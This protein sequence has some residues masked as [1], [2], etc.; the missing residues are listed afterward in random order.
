MSSAQT[1]TMVLFA[2]AAAVGLSGCKKEPSVDPGEASPAGSSDGGD[3]LDD[4]A[5]DDDDGR[6]ADE[7]GV[8]PLSKANFDETV[9]DHFS[10]VSDCYIAALEGNPELAGT[11]EAE[12]TIGDDGQ[13][14][15][16]TVVEGSTLADEG[17]IACIDAAAKTWDFAVPSHGEMT[18]RYPF[19]LAPG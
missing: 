5:A 14:V 9:H 19:N 17:L 18:L 12:F 16:V 6:D 7:A 13:V 4:D 10:E 3:V 15:S 2:V 1:S 8:E 11:L